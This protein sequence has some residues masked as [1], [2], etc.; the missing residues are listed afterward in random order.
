MLKKSPLAYAGNKF[1]QLLITTGLKRSFSF[2]PLI[3]HHI[4]FKSIRFR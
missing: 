3:S 4:T 1:R 2:S